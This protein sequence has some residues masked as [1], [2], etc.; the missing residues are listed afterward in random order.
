MEPTAP[1]Q[2]SLLKFY[3]DALG[4]QYVALLPLA[5]LVALALTL[6]L[7]IRGRGPMA[8][9]GLVLAISLPMLVGLYGAIDGAMQSYLLIAT[10]P[11]SPK[12]S[13]L[14]LG[15]SMALV[16]AQ[17]GMWLMLPSLLVGTIGA[18]LRALL[19]RDQRS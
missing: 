9:S 12:P 2:T 15:W 8:A 10:S 16:S 4:L 19:A 18:S 17:V 6:A 14:A 1:V 11:T 7:V 13:E 3:V 5:G